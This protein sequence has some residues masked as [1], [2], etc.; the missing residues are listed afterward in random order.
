MNGGYAN[1]KPMKKYLLIFLLGCLSVPLSGQQLHTTLDILH[2]A[3]RALPED[4]LDLIVVN[5]TVPQPA[6]FG[7]STGQDDKIIHSVDVDVSKAA[8][9][10]LLGTARTLDFSRLFASVGL[11]PESQNTSASF[12]TKSYL[13]QQAIAKLCADYR[14]DAALVCNQL[15][16]YDIINSF[17]TVDYTY[18]AYTEAY[19]VSNWTLQFPD[20][21][22]QSFSYS[23]T[24]YWEGE[25]A[26]RVEALQ[27]LPNRQAALLDMS[28]WAGEQFA[29][30]FL[31]TWET[32]DRYLYENK[33]I[34]IQRGLDAFTHK[35][36][37]EAIA[38]WSQLYSQ[39]AG[40]RKPAD[41]ISRAYAAANTAN[42]YEI[43]DNLPEALAWAKKAAEAFEQI[44]TADAAQQ[45]INL[46]YYAH[47]L[48]E[49][50]AER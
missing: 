45:T 9:Y 16:L 41:R 23:D 1:Y 20:G 3:Q 37:E 21:R 47:Q 39:L 28:E 6:D 44:N 5:N 49:R 11:V 4:L 24:L 2:P 15:V 35:R 8:T 48:K 26:S 29:R 46:Q 17:L 40:S 42:T 27:K 12:T 22:Q 43:T 13:S 7:H 31:P 14:A 18:Y 50:I 36:W 38:I 34:D 32:V 25:A 30:E 19:L 10:L 33:N